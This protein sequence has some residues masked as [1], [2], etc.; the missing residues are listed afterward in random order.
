MMSATHTH[1]AGTACS[2]FQSDP[3]PAYLDFLSERI[4]KYN[5]LD[6]TLTD[7]EV[8]KIFCF[9]DNDL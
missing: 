4:A 6:K 3:D 9:F 2:V 8:M 7:F 5:N 1:S